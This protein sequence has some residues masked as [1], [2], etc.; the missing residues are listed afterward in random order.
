MR[1]QQR[2]WLPDRAGVTRLETHGFQTH[3]CSPGYWQKFKAHGARCPI[4]L[5]LV[6]KEQNQKLLK[7]H[8]MSY[9]LSELRTQSPKVGY[10]LIKNMGFQ[11]EMLEDSITEM[12]KNQWQ[13]G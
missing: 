11:V 4:Y 12:G 8:C 10:S 13:T 5:S 9:D 7:G 3:S 2:L 6:R 1:A